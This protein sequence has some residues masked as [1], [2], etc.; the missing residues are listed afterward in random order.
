MNPTRLV[1]PLLWTQAAALSLAL[2]LVQYLPAQPTATTGAVRGRVQNEVTGR[3]LPNARVTVTGTDVAVFTD[4]T[5][6]FR[7]TGVP[8]GTVKIEAFY[9]G[10]E[11]RTLAVEVMPGREVSRDILLGE[12]A[13]PWEK[14]GV[15]K[16]DAFVASSSRLREGEALATNE[17]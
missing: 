15:V 5:G 4:E 8:A 9:S 16:L 17:Q 1:R 3:F 7:L 14:S 13:A 11:P 12:K 2:L 10:L 6:T